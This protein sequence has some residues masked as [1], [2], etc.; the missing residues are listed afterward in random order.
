MAIEDLE[1]GLFG[2]ERMENGVVEG[3]DGQGEEEDG[4]NG[5][6]GG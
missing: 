3:G 5:D 6:D 2:A 4:G 1:K